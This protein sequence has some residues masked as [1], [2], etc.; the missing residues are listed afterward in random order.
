MVNEHRREFL[1]T[2]GTIG[3]ASLGGCTQILEEDKPGEEPPVRGTTDSPTPTETDTPTEEPKPET[4]FINLQK[5]DSA[6]ESPIYDMLTP[7]EDAESVIDYER[8]I[9]DALQWKLDDL[10][11]WAESDY[12][13]PEFADIPEN[14]SSEEWV[15]QQ[16]QEYQNEWYDFGGHFDWDTYKGEGDFRTRA[17]E[18]NFIIPEPA[19]AGFRYV[20]RSCEAR[21]W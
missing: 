18:S 20:L 4:G 14:I 13:R 3:A 16:E 12:T 9:Q 7:A 19:E 6:E 15:R 10:Q 11:H 1:K 2:A 17:T 8:S 5:P 21:C